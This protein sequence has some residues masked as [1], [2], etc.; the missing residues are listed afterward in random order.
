MDFE[1]EFGLKVVAVGS[2]FLKIL[3]DLKAGLVE[4][5]RDEPER[6]DKVGNTICEIL[7][8]DL[9]DPHFEGEEEKGK[10]Y[11]IVADAS[12][13]I[14]LAIKSG[15][16]PQTDNIN[17]GLLSMFITHPAIA[18]LSLKEHGYPDEGEIKR[19][20]EELLGEKKVMTEE[21]IDRIID[22]HIGKG[23]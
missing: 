17:G 1:G 10:A 6:L 3:M 20:K 8:Q 14:M 15:L 21:E 22:E 16:I 13:A 2:T 5:F 7:C 18:L 4:T 9:L 23:E 12:I 11:K 19:L